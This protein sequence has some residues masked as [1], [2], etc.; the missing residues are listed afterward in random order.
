[1]DDSKKKQ[2]GG[3]DDLPEE[4]E[5][6]LGIAGMPESAKEELVAKIGQLAL[7]R[8]LTATMEK[9]PEGKKDELVA[10]SKGGDQIKLTEFMKSNV[11]DFENVIKSEVQS[12]ISEIKNKN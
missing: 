5:R 10:I 3:A 1:M 11:P 7:E 9:V 6:A 4:I 2:V 8:A 12:V